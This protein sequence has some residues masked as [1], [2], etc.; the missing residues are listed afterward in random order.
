[1]NVLA[2][3]RRSG[4]FAL[5]D[6]P[7]LGDRRGPAVE[8]LAVESTRLE[9][10]RIELTVRN[11]GPD[12]VTIAQAQVNDAFVEFSGAERPA[13]DGHRA[14]RVVAVDDRPRPQDRERDE[15]HDEDDRGREQGNVAAPRQ[16]GLAL[17]RSF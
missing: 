8:E 6:G 13:D 5:L 11:D 15:G 10:G 1:M 9:P 14:P 3:L 4:A 17:K 16:W 7:G 12:A 2:T